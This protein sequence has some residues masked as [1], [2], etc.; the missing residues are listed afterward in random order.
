[1]AGLDSIRKE[2]NDID[3]Q[4][5]ELF[6]QRMDCAKRVGEFKKENNLPILNQQRENEIL[7]VVEKEGQE[8]GYAS[9]LLFSNIMEL[10][11]DLQHDIVG[12]GNALK[13]TI[14][15]AKSIF[16]REDSN[17]KIACQGISGANSHQASKLIFT[18]SQPVFKKTWEDVFKA[19]E[20]GEVNYGVLPVENSSAGSV[21]DV[22][23]LMIK[24]KFYVV[25]SLDL[26]IKHCLCG[27]QNSELSDIKEV[28]SH[29]QGLSQCSNY[30]SDN[31]LK[32]VPFD[33]TATAAYAIRER[34]DIHSAAICS[35]KAAEEYG[36]K[37]LKRDFQNS[38]D[39]CTR[40]I[41]ISKELF[42]EKDASKISLCFSLPHTKGSLYNALGRF[43]TNGLNLTKIESR[44]IVNRN[45]EYLFYLDFSGNVFNEKTKKL[46][47]ALSEEMPSFSFFGN[48][49]DL[50]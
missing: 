8:Y 50:Y 14:E 20:S 47:C 43:S 42:I 48:Y 12:S 29:P 38:L 33:N 21:S 41:V 27:L 13:N 26:N 44:P 18:N 32:P 40:F 23:D 10:S 45:F 9:R 34:K 24:Y 39:N 17:L 2:I 37:I 31:N 22:Y 28:L 5:I 15:S 4:L 35:Q 7:D 19:V 16:D 1:M 46:L 11:R 6:K 49:K 36:L 25:A 3:A 30:I